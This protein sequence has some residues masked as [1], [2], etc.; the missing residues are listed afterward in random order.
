MD[1]EYFV[2]FIVD[3]PVSRHPEY[4]VKI[5]FS[6]DVRETRTRLEEARSDDLRTYA[7]YS[8]NTK[9]VEEAARMRFADRALQR[10][11]YKIKKTDLDAFLETV[12]TWEDVKYCTE[13]KAKAPKRS[14]KNVTTRDVQDNIEYAGDSENG[15]KTDRNVDRNTGKNRTEVAKTKTGA[16]ANVEVVAEKTDARD[17]PRGRFSGRPSGASADTEQRHGGMFG[18]GSARPPVEAASRQSRHDLNGVSARS[19]EQ[20]VTRSREQ[21]SARVREQDVT[22]SREQDVTRSREQDSSRVRDQRAHSDTHLDVKKDNTY[23]PWFD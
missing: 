21:D 22:R 1:G 3:K 12:N 17:R 15:K 4:S 14:K 9:R 23:D 20:D 10:G 19:R 5:G 8:G 11:W 13:S 6:N 18:D 2:Y 7:V 16:T